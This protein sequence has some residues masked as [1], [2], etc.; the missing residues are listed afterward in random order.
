M[1]D[2][3]IH[4]NECPVCSSNHIQKLLNIQDY[5]VSQETFEVWHCSKCTFRFTQNIPTAAK[6]GPYYQSANYIS[7]SDSQ[8]GFIHRCYHLVRNYTLQIKRKL[9]QETTGKQIGDL[10]DV[11]A[12]TGA[13]SKVMKNA[14]WTVTGLEPD[15]TARK[16][17]VEINELHLLPPENLYQISP[18]SFDAITMW[19]VLEHVHDLHGYLDKYHSILRKNG[20]LIIA[21][22]NYTSYDA[23]VYQQYWA[24]YDVPRHLYHF[25]PESMRMLADKKGFKINSIRPMWF[26]SF[27]VSMLSE[28]YKTG[29]NQY[30][31]AFWTGLLSNLKTIFDH[32]K[33]SSVIYILEKK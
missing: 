19:H 33:C 26:D 17:A 9:I 16:N 1:N 23:S 31:S 28:Q 21:V 29:G 5:T 11:G 25:S 12:G 4:Y 2:F 13:F 18:E 7:H 15:E 10:L 6:I 22:P 8:D 14:G 27:Y 24:A 20:R 3:P 30:L 32:K